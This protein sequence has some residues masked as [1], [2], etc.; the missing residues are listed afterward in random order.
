MVFNTNPTEND[1]MNSTLFARNF[2]L[3]IIHFSG[4]T[5]WLILVAHVHPQV[6]DNTRISCGTF[7]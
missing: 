3:V 5:V 1:K 4:A 2:E 7:P 6:Y